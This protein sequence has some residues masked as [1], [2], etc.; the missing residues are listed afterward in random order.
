MDENAIPNRYFSHA[1][2]GAYQ[3]YKEQR[4]FSAGVW[5]AISIPCQLLALLSAF[6]HLLLSAVCY[7]MWPEPYLATISKGFLVP[8][9]GTACFLACAKRHR[10]NLKNV[11]SNKSISTIRYL[12]IMS[13][14]SCSCLI[15]ILKW[16]NN[17]TIW[18]L[19]QIRPHQPGPPDVQVFHQEGV[20][21]S[22]WSLVRAYGTVPSPSPSSPPF[23]LRHPPPPPPTPPLSPSIHPP[24][25]HTHTHAHTHTHTHVRR[26][27]PDYEKRRLGI[28]L[29]NSTNTTLLSSTQK[30]SLST[31]NF[32]LSSS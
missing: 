12:P 1:V 6:C 14:W 30:L 21:W 28:P 13:Q 4:L 7:F 17:S 11:T 32:T 16:C 29:G 31:P 22:I 8:E 15:V 10:S 3:G 26:P 5:Y 9:C 23:V 2:A 24:Q 19:R 20:W 27:I 18:N 25:S